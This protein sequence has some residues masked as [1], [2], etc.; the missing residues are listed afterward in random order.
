MADAYI[1]GG[2]GVQ[3]NVRKVVAVLVAVGMAVLLG[4]SAEL[5]WSAAHRNDEVTRL[6]HHGVAVAVTVQRCLGI[7]SGVG[8]GIEFYECDG[9]YQ[10]AGQTHDEVIGGSRNRL[11]PGQTI[12]GVADP[13]RPTV[14]WSAAALGRQHV[15]D[16][17]YIAPA[18]LTA[19]VVVVAGWWEL[20]RRRAKRSVR[21]GF[22]VGL[23]EPDR[24]VEEQ[25]VGDGGDLIEHAQELPL[26]DDH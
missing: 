26:A 23:A 16:T 11:L 15:S 20:R 25:L 1:R 9:T 22:G 24:H 10:L 8:M 19:A 3:V 14:L 5:A 13:G 6:Q 4:I 18:A 21:Q 2:G 17:D 12:A 7:S